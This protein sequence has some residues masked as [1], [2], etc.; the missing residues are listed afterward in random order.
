MNDI[1]DIDD[2]DESTLV[3]GIERGCT[4]PQRRWCSAATTWCPTWCRPRSICT[5]TSRRGPEI[6]SRAHLDVLNPVMARTI[7]EAGVNKQRMDAVACTVGP[8]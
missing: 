3:L 1:D 4:R 8:G 7:V 5:P 2:I 6:P